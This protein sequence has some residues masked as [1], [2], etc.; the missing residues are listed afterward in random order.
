MKDASRAALL[1]ALLVSGCGPKSSSP[2]QTPDSGSPV[3]VPPDAGT[4]PAPIT[5]DEI[6]GILYAN[7]GALNQGYDLVEG[8]G[9]DYV[10]VKAGLLRAY[11]VGHLTAS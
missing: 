7:V 6:S 10:V 2:S 3:S 4:P 11:P 8:H 5:C 9:L 1:F